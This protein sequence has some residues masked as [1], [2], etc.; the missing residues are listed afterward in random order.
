MI[1]PDGTGARR[2]F[3]MRS[4]LLRTLLLLLGAIIIGIVLFA[5]FYGQ[6][7]ERAAI[8][9][10]VQ[11]ENERLQRYQYKVQLLEMNLQQAREIVGRLT[12]LAGIEYVFPPMP[13]DSAILGDNEPNPVV[14]ARPPDADFNYPH[15]L[16]LNGTISQQFQ[17]KDP[18]RYHPGVDI[19]CRIGTPVLS[20]ANGTVTSADYDSVYGNVLIVQNSDTIETLYGHNDTIL[21]HPGQEVLAGSRVALSGNTGISTAPHLHYEVRL[22]GE[23]INPLESS[24]DQER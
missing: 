2:E 24:Y 19:A 22:K 10:R 15:G 20:T 16:P 3:R 7:L 1:I 9:E 23:P 14:M 8:T 21:V 12:E 18:E 6:V 17:I 11:A 13:S 5:A 4:W